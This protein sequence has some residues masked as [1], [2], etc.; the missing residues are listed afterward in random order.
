MASCLL[1]LLLALPTCASFYV[2]A[3][4]SQKSVG[5]GVNDLVVGNK[6][7]S[8]FLARMKMQIYVEGKVDTAT[9]TA[10]ELLIDHF[11][12][13]NVGARP[14]LSRCFR[15][16]HALSQ[17]LHF[18]QHAHNLREELLWEAG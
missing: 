5:I 18:L 12:I 11:Q 6:C 1:I 16:E 8:C 15:H 7:S 17:F 2:T 10:K 13:K 4:F 3:A 9:S 14:S